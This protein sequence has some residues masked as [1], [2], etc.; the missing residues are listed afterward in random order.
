MI[1][2]ETFNDK[3]G[4][5]LV[6]VLIVISVSLILAA[7]AV[8]IIG[9]LQ[10]SAQLND[11]TSDIIQTLRIARERSISR[12]NNENHGVFF[13]I[14]AGADSYILYQGGSYDTRD[15]DYDVETTLPDSI[16][17]TTTITGDEINFSK[18]L[19]VP[20]ETG[21]IDLISDTGGTRSVSS[22]SIGLI[23]EN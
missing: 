20:D 9:N 7:S 17:M 5:T 22:N 18:G 10:G 14:N 6:E 16:T 19:G 2:P 15:T 8:P 13:E 1:L 3:K 21:I 4:F 11:N 23:E 12:L